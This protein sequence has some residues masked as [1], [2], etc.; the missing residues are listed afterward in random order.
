MA[1]VMFNYWQEY[2]DKVQKYSNI[3]TCWTLGY[4][5]SRAIAVSLGFYQPA[6]DIFGSIGVQYFAW[7]AFS[8]VVL[9]P[10]IL[11]YLKMYDSK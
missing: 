6:Q 11:T 2:K 4:V 10:A 8:F 5:I 1:T 9:S 3:Y 7:W